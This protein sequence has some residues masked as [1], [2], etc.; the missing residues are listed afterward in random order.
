[1]GADLAN[2]A[3]VPIGGQSN[4]V[5]A[6]TGSFNGLGHSMTGITLN[7]A[8]TP[9]YMG[10][11]Q[12]ISSTASLSNLSL[13]I[14]GTY[15]NNY[16]GGLVGYSTGGKISNVHLSGSLTSNYNTSSQILYLGGIVGQNYGGNI[17][18]NNASVD[19]QIAQASTATQISQSYIGGIIGQSRGTDIISNSKV[20]S[21]TQITYNTANKTVD[22]GGV[23]GHAQGS[24]SLSNL[25]SA[26]TINVLNSGTISVGG[27]IGNVASGNLSDLTSEAILN[28]PNV[29]SVK[30][31]GGVIGNASMGTTLNVSN[32]KFLSPGKIDAKLINSMNGGMGG[33]AGGFKS[34][35]T[36]DGGEV[37]GGI[38]SYLGRVGGAIGEWQGGTVKNFKVSTNNLEVLDGQSNIGGIVG[39]SIGGVLESSEFSG[40]MT[41]GNSMQRVGGLIGYAASG[42]TIKNS[43]VTGSATVGTNSQYFGG[44]L[45]QGGVKLDSNSFGGTFSAGAGSKYVA[46]LAGSRNTPSSASEEYL[47]NTVSK[48]ITIDGVSPTANI[49]ATPTF[50]GKLIGDGT[51]ST[52]STNNIYGTLVAYTLGT[53]GS[54]VYDGTS[55]LLSNEWSTA[56]IFAGTDYDGWIL[57]T[58]YVFKYNNAIT[59]SFTDAGSYTNIVVDILKD[60]FAAASTGN[61]AGSLAIAKRAVD[62]TVTKDYDTNANFTTGFTLGNI[63][64]G[65]TITISS[66]SASVSSANPNAY[67]SFAS[68]TLVLSDATNYTFTGGMVSATINKLQ[69]TYTLPT[70]TIA[71][72][73]QITAGTA[74]TLPTPTLTSGTTPVNA[75]TVKVYDSQNND[76]TADAIA[77]RLA[78][79]AYTLKTVINDAIYDVSNASDT[80]AF[81]VIAATS[82]VNSST[83]ATSSPV[84]VVVSQIADNVVKNV[85]QTIV[86]PQTTTPAVVAG[87]SQVVTPPSVVQVVQP[88]GNEGST[89]QGGAIVNTGGS[90]QISLAVAAN[91]NPFASNENI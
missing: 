2:Q 43:S 75:P 19:M 54:Y 31:I 15:A 41:L 39:I 78:A 17:T 52:Y 82:T 3:I 33:L 25:Y 30:Y 4:P 74:I 7:T 46:S 23:V 26:A 53:G 20:F 57:G 73:A 58:D 88:V 65:Q 27:I 84:E 66:G 77:G 80:I 9:S 28:F 40:T 12:Q 68:N 22:I 69:A 36:V 34:A 38:Y 72:N 87:A 86:A 21:T 62:I 16:L 10:L 60:G 63:V 76:V 42:G 18:I 55:H 83:D 79:G 71:N 45:G 50:H 67:N 35:G 91:A 14:S 47:N 32:I 85:E 24:I 13:N 51:L 56:N 49:G 29:T 81:N 70:T 48:T 1:M 61:T 44:L 37:T 5:P 8:A 11:F 89:T 6:F 90:T 64:S 59:T